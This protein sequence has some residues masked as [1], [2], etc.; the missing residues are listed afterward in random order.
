M[1]VARSQNSQL[2]FVLERMERLGQKGTVPLA[3]LQ[4]TDNVDWV[5]TAVLP[6]LRQIL[7]ASEILVL[8]LSLTSGVHMGPGTWSVAACPQ[9]MES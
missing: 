9:R 5:R 6:Q 4:Y 8:P 1:G 2:D 3:L 7:P